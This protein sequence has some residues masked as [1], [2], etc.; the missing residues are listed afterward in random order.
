MSRRVAVPL[1]PKVKLEIER[2][3]KL[4]VI[5][6]ITEPTEWCA[7]M[8]VVP[9]PSGKVR[10]CVDLTKLNVNVCREQHVLP[11]IETTLAQLGGA[12]FFSKLDANSDIN[13]PRGI[14]T[15]YFHHHFKRYKFNRLPFGITSTPEH[16]QRRMNKILANTEGTVCLI[17][18]VLVYG[19]TQSE[20][21]QRLLKVLKKLS[22]AV[23][24]R[25][26]FA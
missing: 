14:Q 5:T 25:S 26:V 9:K 15:D 4:G 7:G 20:H 24:S 6:K 17:D 1:L 3:V 22:E 8:V 10:I 13:G 19:S 2:M 12:K 16:F 11:S 23:V 21:D 18:D